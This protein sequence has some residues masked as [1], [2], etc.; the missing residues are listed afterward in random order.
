M[1]AKTLLSAL[2]VTGLLTACVG[3]RSYDAQVQKTGAY[4]KL[5]AQLQGEQAADQAQIEQLQNLVK[6]TL[7]SG[8]LFPEGGWELGEAG[9]ALLTKAAPALKELSGQRIVI[10]GFT[11]NVPIGPA[12]RQRF[13]GNVELSKARAEAV[14]AFLTAQGVPPAIIST[15]GLGESHP[16]AGNDTAQGRASNRRVEIDIVEEP[17]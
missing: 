16:V 10:K 11:D 4:T 12:Q 1:N 15:V 8:I 14:A 3:P 13:P 7:A 17:I 6:L 5:D 9:K 2:A